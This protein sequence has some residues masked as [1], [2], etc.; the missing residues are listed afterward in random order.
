MYTYI[1]IYTLYIIYVYAG[2]GICKHKFQ[3]KAFKKPCAH[4]HSGNGGA[5]RLPRSL[6]LGHRV[7]TNILGKRYFFP[8]MLVPRSL[9][10]GHRVLG[11]G[12]WCFGGFGDFEGSR[13][14]GLSNKFPD[15]REDLESRS[16]NL[17]PY[18]E[19]FWGP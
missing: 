2:K 9:A 19:W 10:L 12:L 17:G 5:N 6:A 7:N 15:P 4:R 8:N 3:L 14:R 16:P 11:F 13:P 18:S 1:Y